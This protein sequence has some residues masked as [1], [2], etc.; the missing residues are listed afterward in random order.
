MK[1]NEKEIK[2]IMEVFIPLLMKETKGINA[3]GYSTCLYTG[4]SFNE[5]FL[6][7]LSKLMDEESD[8]PYPII[9]KLY[10]AFEASLIKR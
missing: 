2:Q 1:L 3:G 7:N 6:E 9:E 8:V 10:D 5:R 4:K